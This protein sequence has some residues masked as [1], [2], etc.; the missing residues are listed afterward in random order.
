MKKLFIRD[1]QKWNSFF[2]R[3]D[4]EVKIKD[5]LIDDLNFSVRSISK[6]KRANNIYINGRPA[7]PTSMVKQGD[8]IEIQINEEKAGFIGQDLGVA[9]VYEDQDLIVA[10]KPPYMV[11]HPTKSHFDGTLANAISYHIDRRGEGP[12]IRFVNRLDMNTSGLVVVAKNSYA[13]HKLS[14]DMGQ[15][16]VYKEYLAIVE[17]IISEDS[18]VLDFPI[19]RETEDSI[20]RVVDPRGQRSITHFRTLQRL[21]GA[22]LLSLRLETGRTHQIRVHLSHTGHPIIGDDL[23]GKPDS[24]LIS[25]QA[26]HAYR[27]GFDQPR[28]GDRIELTAD[29]PQDMV[30]LLEKLGGR[31]D[32]Y[33]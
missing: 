27:I 29:L 10:D 20:S 17:G 9:I 8:I 4:R 22:S 32:D 24:P 16:N 11:V 7:K 2:I 23:Y 5:L 31:V 15:D 6:M 26:L 14:L 28:F 30:E 3:V 19:Y 1:R 21:D 18:G 12:R 33:K 13:H 25:R